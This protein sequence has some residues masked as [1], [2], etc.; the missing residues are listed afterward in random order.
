MIS[1]SGKSFPK[2][3]VA[4]NRDMQTCD[5][6]HRAPFPKHCAGQPQCQVSIHLCNAYWG[7]PKVQSCTNQKPVAPTQSSN[8]SISAA[9]LQLIDTALDL[10]LA[11][12]NLLTEALA[13][14]PVQGLRGTWR[15]MGSYKWG[16]KSPNLGYKYCYPTYNYN[17]TYN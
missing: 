1:G 16:Y 3:A 5:D 15:F 14:P 13:V 6:T 11:T 4:S 9:C 10:Q 8:P 7:H 2:S 12:L 17:P